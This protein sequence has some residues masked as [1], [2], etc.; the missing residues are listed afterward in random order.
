HDADL[1]QR[2]GV[3]ARKTVCE[4]FDSRCCEAE[5][6]RHLASGTR[7][8]RVLYLSGDRGV[9][10]RGMKGAS[11]H[12]RSLIKALRDLGVESLLV[13][14]SGGRRDGVDPPAELRET[15]AGPSLTLAAKILAR[16]FGGGSAAGERAWLRIVD[17]WALFRLADEAAASW[18]PDLVYERYA[19]SSI[20]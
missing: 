7:I 19:L 18:R 20:A 14:R 3:E 8:E 2:L 1:R 11:I 4:R 5:R 12:V 10:I 17:N 15:R 13:T 6:I 9:P 16:F